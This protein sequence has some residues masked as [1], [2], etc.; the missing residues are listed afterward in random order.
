MTKKQAEREDA[1][2]KL[3]EGLKPG[4]TVHT[5]LRH[6]SR[7]GMSRRID[8]VKLTND[9]PRYLTWLAA[10]AIG[11]RSTGNG[12]GLVV[13]GCGMDMGF[14]VVYE[15]SR[16]LFPKGFKVAEN[17]PCKHCQDRPGFDGLGQTCK[18]CQ[19]NGFIEV[20]VPGR[21]GD[22]SGWDNDGGYALKQRWL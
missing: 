15:L 11:C 9:E 20:P 19:G 3:R 21:N 13:G 17:Q 2:A 22:K 12:E 7:S 5:I 10:K 16:V 4:D 1:I 18:H 6:V 8:L 14:H